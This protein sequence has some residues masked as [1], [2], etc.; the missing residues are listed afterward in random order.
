VSL[1]DASLAFCVATNV[2][3]FLFRPKVVSVSQAT[4]VGKLLAPLSSSVLEESWKISLAQSW[5]FR[6]TT[7]VSRALKIEKETNSLVFEQFYTQR[8]GRPVFGKIAFMGKCAL[9][10]CGF[11]F[12][13]ALIFGLSEYFP[14]MMNYFKLH[15]CY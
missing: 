13:M 4:T 11:D 7:T 3:T 9:L 5:I 8:A 12:S 6:K 14:F 15:I 10:I 1:P 2:P